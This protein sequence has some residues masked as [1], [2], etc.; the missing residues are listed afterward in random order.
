MSAWFA[1]PWCRPHGRPLKSQINFFYMAKTND[2]EEKGKIKLDPKNTDHE[3]NR[4]H[5][6]ASR[7][8]MYKGPQQTP[9]NKRVPT[10]KR[11]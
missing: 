10:K 6:T 11:Y 3:M 2:K 8:P 9:G 4:A 7:Q 5:A 1:I